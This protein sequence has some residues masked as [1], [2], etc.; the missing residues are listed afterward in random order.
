MTAREMSPEDAARYC[1]ACCDP[2]AHVNDHNVLETVCPHIRLPV[3]QRR[4]FSAARLRAADTPYKAM[5]LTTT[6]HK[7]K[8]QT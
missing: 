4:Q 6:T 8:E 1:R 5:R 2:E 3:A 7:H